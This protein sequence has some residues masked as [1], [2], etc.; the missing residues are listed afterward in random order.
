MTLNRRLT[1]ALGVTALLGVAAVQAEEL[2]RASVPFAFEARGKTME[3]GPYSAFNN[4]G[5]LLIRNNATS[6]GVYLLLVPADLTKPGQSSMTFRCYGSECFLNQIQFGGIHRVY[7]LRPSSREVELAKVGH[8]QV[9][10]IAM[11]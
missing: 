11:R 1:I 7:Q 10:P 6:Q 5:V 9:T 8:P 3:A 2:G 4:G